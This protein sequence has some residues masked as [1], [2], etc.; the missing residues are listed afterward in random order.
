ME[1]FLLS[2]RP[3]YMNDGVYLNVM[4]SFYEKM[5]LMFFFWYFKDFCDCNWDVLH[6]LASSFKAKGWLLQLTF[7][8]NSIAF[9]FY[10]GME[11]WSV[12]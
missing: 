7:C 10:K 4:I 5:H 2:R 9:V 11:L 8:S 3:F 6:L 1:P 12:T